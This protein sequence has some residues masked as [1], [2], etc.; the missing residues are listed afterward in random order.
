MHSRSASSGHIAARWCDCTFASSDDEA[1]QLPCCAV[2]RA[3]RQRGEEMAGRTQ[4]ID[5]GRG[6]QAFS[7]FVAFGMGEEIGRIERSDTAITRGE[8]WQ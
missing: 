4:T 2:A 6:G 5:T 8:S 7:F 1:D 3:T